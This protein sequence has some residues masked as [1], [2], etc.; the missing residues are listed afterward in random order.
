EHRLADDELADEVHE[1]IDL[2]DRDADRAGVVTT[3]RRSAAVLVR[4]SGTRGVR[5]SGLVRGAFETR[6]VRGRFRIARRIRGRRIDSRDLEIALVLD[7][8]ECLAHLCLGRGS[9][10]LEGPAQIARLGL[11]LRELRQRRVVALDRERAEIA[12]EAQNPEGV[13]AGSEQRPVR[14][15]ANPPARLGGRGALLAALPRGRRRGVAGLGLEHRVDRFARSLDR[16]VV[17]RALV[18]GRDPHVAGPVDGPEQQRS[19]VRG[20]RTLTAAG[21]GEQRLDA[22]RELADEA[23]TE[24]ARAA[25]D[26]MRRAEDRVDALTVARRVE[27]LVVEQLAFHEV[28]A[29]EALFEEGL[30]ELGY[31]DA[32]GRRRVVPSAE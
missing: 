22:V 30:D 8:L 15:E 17:E 23:E 20:Q 31:V 11:E 14:R 1:L 16:F 7:P 9:L 27:D 19:P 29:L 32:H 2:L 18:P 21:T 13:V 4:A 24:R 12:Q 28:Q 3:I 26:R 25:F 6:R 10:E 5:R